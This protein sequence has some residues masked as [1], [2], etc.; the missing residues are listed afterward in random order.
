MDPAQKDTKLVATKSS[1]IKFLGIMLDG[2][3]AGTKKW[4]AFTE[5]LN[6]KWQGE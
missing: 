1:E 3:G 2:Y 6:Y 4:S 5:K